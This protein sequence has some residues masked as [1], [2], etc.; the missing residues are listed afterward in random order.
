MSYSY[1]L[2][3]LLSTDITSLK[4]NVLY[5]FP[6]QIS[7]SIIQP[8]RQPIHTEVI[9]TLVLRNHINKGQIDGV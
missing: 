8:N 1:G 5:D 7:K 9:N 3:K 6:E 4:N 2:L